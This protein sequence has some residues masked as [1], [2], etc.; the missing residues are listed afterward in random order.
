MTVPPQNKEK[1]HKAGP[2]PGPEQT[3]RNWPSLAIA[4]L[5]EELAH[6]SKDIGTNVQGF[7]RKF[8]KIALAARSQAETV[9]SLILAVQAIDV[10]GQTL[11]LSELARSLGETLSHLSGKI[12]HLSSRSAAMIYALHDVQTEINSMQ[13]SIAQIEKIN[14]RTNLLS[15]NAKIEAARAGPAG[16]GFAVVASEVGELAQAVNRLSD[17]VRRQMSS[18][19]EGLG[20]G[21]DLLKEIAAIEISEADLEANARIKALMDKLL[22]QNAAIAGAMQK[23]VASSKQM[24]RDASEAIADVRF[25]DGAMQRV[26]DVSTAL[27][28][29]GQ[30]AAA[31]SP[32]SQPEFLGSPPEEAAS[33]ILQQIADCFSAPEMR[34]RFI[35]QTQLERLSVYQRNYAAERAGILNADR[36]KRGGND[37]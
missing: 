9:Q 19:S 21:D 23:T 7:G 18:V 32:E 3:V 4:P 14:K 27:S 6:A 16:R 15:L 37:N 20:R 26:Q 8:K 17:T 25:S 11:P 22:K 12:I 1:G 10:D 33:A 13:E 34:E 2:A 30:A 28:V 35:A 5:T 24:D 29:I 31:V 36:L